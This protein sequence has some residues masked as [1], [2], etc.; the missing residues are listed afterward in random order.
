[1]TIELDANGMVVTRPVLGWTT[2]T[3][4]E[5]AVILQIQY[6]EKPADIDTGGKS[7]QVVLTPPQCLEL[8]EVLT[9][10]AQ[11]ILNFPVSGPKQ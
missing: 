9:R 7:L 1:M 8:A 2:A 5:I 4:A 3:A 6:S 10:N 11:R